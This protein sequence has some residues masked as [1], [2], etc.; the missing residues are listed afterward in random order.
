MTKIKHIKSLPKS[1]HGKDIILQIENH[2]FWTIFSYTYATIHW[3]VM[4]REIIKID[5]GNVFKRQ[6]QIFSINK[7]V[8]T[9]KRT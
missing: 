2:A 3:R 6:S 4:K 9:G 8:M 7:V 1:T 5:Y